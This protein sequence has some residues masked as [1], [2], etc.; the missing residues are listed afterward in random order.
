MTVCGLVRLDG[1]NVR[2]AVLTAMLA[3]SARGLPAARGVHLDG[4]FGAVTAAD[5]DADPTPP[6]AVDDA[7]L[8]LITDRAPRA[9]GPHRSGPREPAAQRGRRPALIA[10]GT[11]TV[12]VA[13]EP[14]RSRLALTRP[15]GA[16]TEM[17]IWT[18]GRVFAFGTELDQV[19]AAVRPSA[20]AGRPRW[21]GRGEVLTVAVPVR[22]PGLTAVRPP[23]PGPSPLAVGR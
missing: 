19:R 14:S 9:S 11:R 3:C 10:A 2:R 6:G 23:T 18:D 15:A 22:R 8:V 20:S 16:R 17:I 1:V 12:T 7:G 5:P 4:V 13:W 21:L